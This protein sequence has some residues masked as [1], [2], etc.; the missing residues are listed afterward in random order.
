M[1][2][3]NGIIFIGDPGPR[4]WYLNFLG[5]SLKVIPADA[6]QLAKEAIEYRFGLLTESTALDRNVLSGLNAICRSV[7]IL[8]DRPLFSPDEGVVAWDSLQS[9]LLSRK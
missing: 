6:D 5:N 9:L 7:V 3:N 1:K 4:R 2:K 8:T